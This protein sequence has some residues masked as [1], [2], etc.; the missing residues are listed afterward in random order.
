[1]SKNTPVYVAGTQ[2]EAIIDDGW[3]RGFK[4]EQTMQELEIQ[5]YSIEEE[6]VLI[7]WENWDDEL[8]KHR[9]LSA[10]SAGIIKKVDL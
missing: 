8:A 5:G 3:A 7:M 2:A 9:H 1:M 4:I 10:I 6:A